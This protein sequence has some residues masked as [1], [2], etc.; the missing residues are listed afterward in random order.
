MPMILNDFVPVKNLHPFFLAQNILGSKAMGRKKRRGLELK[1]FCYYCDREFDDEKVLLL[2]QKAKHF[3]CSQ[4][5]RKLDT[6]TGLVV[7]LLQVHKESLSKVPNAKKDRDGPEIV[8]HGM[9]GVPS[10]LLMEK[11]RKLAEQKGLNKSSKGAHTIFGS[12][13][14][15]AP[16]LQTF[17]G[18]PF[19]PDMMAMMPQFTQGVPAV[20]GAAN[21]GWSPGIPN[22]PPNPI[23]LVPNFNSAL[24]DS[25]LKGTSSQPLDPALA[26]VRMDGAGA[27][28]NMF[29][30]FSF[31][32]FRQSPTPPVPLSDATPGSKGVTITPPNVTTANPNL[33]NFVHIGGYRNKVTAPKPQNGVL[34]YDDDQVSME[35]HRASLPKYN[36]RLPVVLT[37]AA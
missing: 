22:P 20:P 30:S 1:P 28:N 32:I 15:A 10:E 25:I 19:P 17:N 11:Q 27:A 3:K 13:M 6:A 37:P 9:S 36:Y 24:L 14:F 18:L 33:V 29:E 23:S 35:E 16:T 12:G 26:A 4:C 7:H 34:V 31:P 2:H 21:P 8:I 5:N